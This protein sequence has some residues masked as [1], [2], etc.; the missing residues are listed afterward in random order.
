MPILS[1]IRFCQLIL[2]RTETGAQLLYRGI[3]LR[4][5]ARPSET[6]I[7]ELA[8]SINGMHSSIHG[9]LSCMLRYQLKTSI[10]APFIQRD[11][12]SILK[13]TMGPILELQQQAH[14]KVLLASPHCLRF[15]QVTYPLAKLSACKQCV[16]EL[17]AVTQSNVFAENTENL[18]LSRMSG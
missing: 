2:P 5:R 17:R 4:P 15:I 6:G 14:D 7:V 9:S 16:R 11:L 8:V 3:L 13:P 18:L 1:G 10:L 12:M